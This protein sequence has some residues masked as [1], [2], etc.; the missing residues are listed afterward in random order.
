MADVPRSLRR[1]T[2]ARVA[3]TQD[4]DG[5]VGL[6][7]LRH[8]PWT[9]LWVGSKGVWSH[10][11]DYV[12]A[13]AFVD[14]SDGMYLLICLGTCEK[15]ATHLCVV[16]TP[17][18][19]YRA[20]R[21]SASF[22]NKLSVVS[23]GEGEVP[24]AVL[25]AVEV[26]M[27]FPPCWGCE[28]SLRPSAKRLLLPSPIHSSCLSF[29]ELPEFV[30]VLPPPPSMDRILYHCAFDEPR[31]NIQVLR[32]RTVLA[33]LGLQVPRGKVLLF[34]QLQSM[35]GRAGVGTVRKLGDDNTIFRGGGAFGLFPTIPSSLNYHP[36]YWDP[37]N[38]GEHTFLS[39][40]QVLE[41]F[42]VPVGSRTWDT[43]MLLGVDSPRLAHSGLCAGWS[44]RASSS[45]FHMLKTWPR[46]PLFGKPHWTV[47]HLF[48]GLDIA[49]AG[50]LPAGQSASLVYAA[51]NHSVFL[52]A[53]GRAHPDAVCW[54][55][56]CRCSAESVVCCSSV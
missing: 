54:S 24:S 9:L 13:A 12:F 44:A 52:D 25:D 3:S 22:L 42:E 7:L 8:A 5:A 1:S 46:S 26:V 37:R 41:C 30:S 15:T 43:V 36:I 29:F 34:G 51:E 53:L 55:L 33:E 2:R 14:A 21:A 10:A 48:A 47:A 45:I 11:R 49:S 38:G 56:R 17:G 39:V 28:R 20:E 4:G 35:L 32:E 19:E 16:I 50:F 40:P 31:R 27:E 6:G 23:E 18:G